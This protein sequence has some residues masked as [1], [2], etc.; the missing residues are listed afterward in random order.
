LETTVRQAPV[1]GEGP[2]ALIEHRLL[3]VT[4]DLPVV[5]LVYLAK[6]QVEQEVLGTTTVLLPTQQVKAVQAELQVVLVKVLAASMAVVV[7]QQM[8]AVAEQ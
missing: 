2:A 8:Q 4:L 1:V 7:D 5:V 3:V 6:D